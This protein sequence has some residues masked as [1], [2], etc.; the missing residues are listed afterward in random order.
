M[1]IEYTRDDYLVSTDK[2]KLD[3]SV[4]HG[5]LS[6][7]Y[8]AKNIPMETVRKSVDNSLAFG[9]YHAGK[10]IGFARLI[11]DYAAFAYLADVFIL[12]EYRG[13]GL[14]K[15]LMECILAHPDLQGLR[16]WLLATRDAHGLYSQFGFTPLNAP[17]KWMEITLRN[18][19]G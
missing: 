19:Y 6:R 2:G 1:S 13:R 12:E 3:L 9:V 14:S 18:P 11:T 4:I 17:E 15:W 10:Q 8:W 5:F 7:S 16:R